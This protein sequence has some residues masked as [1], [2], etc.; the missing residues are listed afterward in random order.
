VNRSP[1]GAGIAINLNTGHTDPGDVITVT[2]NTIEDITTTNVSFAGLVV[3]GDPGTTPI[4]ITVVGNTLHGTGRKML[5]ADDLRG[6]NVSA[7]TFYNT[8][9]AQVDISVGAQDGNITGNTFVRVSSAGTGD[10]TESITVGAN[11]AGINISDNRFVGNS[12]VTN[13][14]VIQ[15]GASNIYVGPNHFSGIISNSVFSSSTSPSV[16]I[17][18]GLGNQGVS[19]N[20]ANKV[21]GFL[22]TSDNIFQAQNVMP[23]VSTYTVANLP[24][25]VQANQ[26]AYASNGRKAGEG[27]GS[28]TGVLVFRDTT[29]WRACDT[30]A[31][32]AA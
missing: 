29:A 16:V 4:A 26:I 3:A 13:G 28:G 5:L 1:K 17:W 30:G 31:T 32:V 11:G 21:F 18:G 9:S 19:V 25:D 10:Q 20:A 6:F 8:G 24:T 7:N 22:R 27:A 14:I 15:S 23:G 12:R 2:G